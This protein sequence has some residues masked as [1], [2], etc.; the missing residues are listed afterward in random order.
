M[1]VLYLY[2]EVFMKK[3]IIGL[4]LLFVATACTASNSVTENIGVNDLKRMINNKETFILEIVQDGCSHC[5]DFA[6][7]FKS[8]LK[9]AKLTAKVINVSNITQK[10]YE[11]M[12]DVLSL[13]NF[14]T[15]LVMF[16]D[17]G[18]E[19]SS[20]KRIVG[21]HDKDYVIDKFES[22]GFIK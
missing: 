14:G 15:P 2:D 19:T 5:A 1:L 6:P 12:K 3:L 22:N 13:S 16:F 18:V 17:K 21:S 8:A 9:E 11:D 20:L 7:K 4:L 10:E